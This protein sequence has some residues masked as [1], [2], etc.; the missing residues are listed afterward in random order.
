MLQASKIL[1][2]N[3]AKVTTSIEM[4]T[5]KPETFPI[6]NRFNIHPTYQIP[7][8]QRVFRFG[9]N[10]TVVEV[11]KNATHSYKNQHTDR[12]I[13]PPTANKHIQFPPFRTQLNSIAIRSTNPEIK[14]AQI[15]LN[16]PKPPLITQKNP[17]PNTQK[18]SIKPK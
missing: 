18:S 15:A 5:L 6:F 11:P 12:E 17:D 14:F 10:G 7:Q 16:S 1:I 9:N 2:N 4:K 13:F 8:N 3:N